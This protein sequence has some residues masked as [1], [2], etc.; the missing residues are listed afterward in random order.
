MSTR[1][2][3]YFEVEVQARF[4]A[5]LVNSLKIKF[6]QFC[7]C[8]C[9]MTKINNFGKQNS[10]FG[11]VVPLAMFV[12]FSFCKI[13]W[14]R[15]KLKLVKLSDLI[16]LVSSFVRSLQRVILYEKGREGKE[17]VFATSGLCLLW[18]L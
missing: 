1:S 11:F 16:Q 15:S 10:I 7:V 18:R 3:H 14:K 8:S 17:K 13:M 9:D 5:G 12:I 6:D 2:G 4:E